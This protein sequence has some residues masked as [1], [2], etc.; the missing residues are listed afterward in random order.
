[1]RP[2]AAVQE[3]YITSVADSY[4]NSSYLVPYTMYSFFAYHHMRM[5]RV[6]LVATYTVFIMSLICLSVLENLLI[7]LLGWYL[8]LKCNLTWRAQKTHKKWK[9]KWL[10]IY[11]YFFLGH[12]NSFV[13]FFT[14]DSVFENT[15]WVCVDENYLFVTC[16]LTA[17]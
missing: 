13:L 5:F 6:R 2:L 3:Y 1:M 12:L 17:K 11:L 9:L 7:L 4:N 10:S 16:S 8:L 14:F 15:I